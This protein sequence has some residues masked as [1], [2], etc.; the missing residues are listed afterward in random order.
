[1]ALWVLKALTDFPP[2][3]PARLIPSSPASVSSGPSSS[4]HPQ[5]HWAP[6]LYPPFSSQ[7]SSPHNCWRAGGNSAGRGAIRNLGDPGGFTAHPPSC[8]V[9]ASVK[10]A[11]RR[12]MGS[13]MPPQQGSAAAKSP[14]LVLHH[15]SS[16][17]TRGAIL[18]PRAPQASS[19]SP[20]PTGP[21]PS[22]PCQS[23]PVLSSPLPRPG[24]GNHHLVPQG[25]AAS[26][27]GAATQPEPSFQPGSDASLLPKISQQQC[28]SIPELPAWPPTQLPTPQHDQGLCDPC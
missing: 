4:T 28:P 7:A 2:H 12:I 25:S 17:E 6:F 5:T 13:R 23:Q 8:S 3:P 14:E 20:E 10:L 18:Q 15:S 26:T 24:P 19:S 16:S 1:M 22:S 9:S 27:E 11:Q 21:S